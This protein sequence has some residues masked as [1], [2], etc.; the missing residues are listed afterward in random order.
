MER[1]CVWK[2][3]DSQ[4]GLDYWIVKLDNEGQI[5]W[6][7][8][9]GGQYHDELRSIIQTADGG[10]MLAGSSNSTATGDKTEKD[11]VKAIIG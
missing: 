6:Q 5:E 8:T 11:M 2:K 7:K 3:E 1:R 10:Y 9:I 4:G